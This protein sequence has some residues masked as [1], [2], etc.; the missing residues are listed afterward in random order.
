MATQRVNL[1]TEGTFTKRL[2][3]FVDSSKNPNEM[4]QHSRTATFRAVGASIMKTV[5]S[6]HGMNAICQ[7]TEC[8]GGLR[9]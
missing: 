9:A 4:T 3:E 5:A 6:N 7:P 1:M 2:A 8:R